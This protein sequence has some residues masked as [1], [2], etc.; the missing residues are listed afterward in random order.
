MSTTM[1]PFLWIQTGLCRW[2]LF[3]IR[4]L[5]DWII[6]ILGILAARQTHSWFLHS[7]PRVW[8]V[9]E[10]GLGCSLLLRDRRGL[11][12]RPARQ[13]QP[14]QRHGRRPAPALHL[15][16]PGLPRLAPP[17]PGA[18]ALLLL[19][20]R[21]EGGE[22]GQAAGDLL[23]LLLQRSQTARLGPAQPGPGPQSQVLKGRVWK[24]N[25][26][27]DSFFWLKLKLALVNIN[28]YYIL[29]VHSTGY[30]LTIKRKVSLIH[31]ANWLI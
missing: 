18:V 8:G 26:H 20:P 7:P 21:H 12:S 30:R 2:K 5:I 25:F 14:G 29:R 1:M 3:Y 24:V 22:H 11:D 6:D 9:A 10:C 27:L 16:V 17:G 28:V 31:I 19:Q 13:P 4:Y 15:L 23:L